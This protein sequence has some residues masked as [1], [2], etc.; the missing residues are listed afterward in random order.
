MSDEPRFAVIPSH[1]IPGR[2]IVYDWHTGMLARRANGKPATAG[3]KADA[4]RLAEKLNR[5][6]VCLG[7]RHRRP[8]AD[9][10]DR[11]CPECREA[12]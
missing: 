2:Y 5:N 12:S 11:R 3:T 4:A 7:C 10:V 8:A 6:A 9:M 1:V